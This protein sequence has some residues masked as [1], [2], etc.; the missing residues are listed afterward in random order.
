MH[1][2]SR[3]IYWVSFPDMGWG[4]RKG[5]QHIGE[6]EEPVPWCWT[7][8]SWRAWEST[9]EPP[10]FSPPWKAEEAEF[11]C[12]R[13]N[14]SSSSRVEELTEWPEQG[15]WT[16]QQNQK[17]TG[18]ERENVRHWARSP[19]IW[20]PPE[21]AIHISVSLPTSNNLPRKIPYR[22]AQQCS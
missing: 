3:G 12:Q 16:C 7:L 13:N 10:V 4:V 5:W 17:T 22:C 11:W 20:L 9:G 21:G 1:I 19:F 6:A 14:G 2:Y 18:K 8:P 15:S